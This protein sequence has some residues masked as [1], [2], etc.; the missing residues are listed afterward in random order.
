MAG[1]PRE[2]AGIDDIPLLFR[3]TVASA[4]NLV[5]ELSAGSA[6]QAI[7]KMKVNSRQIEILI[8]FM[9]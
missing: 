1:L 3:L 4:F 7:V 8:L 2:N 9:G 6:D 5:F